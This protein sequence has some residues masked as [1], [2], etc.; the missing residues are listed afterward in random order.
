MNENIEFLEY[1]YKTC[2]MGVKASEK[3]LNVLKEKDNKI[4]KDLEKYLKE[5]EK[6][7]KKSEKILKKYKVEPKTIG[8]MA[9]IMSSFNIKME[10]LQDNSDAKIADMLI[11]GFTCGI[12]D[13]EKRLKNYVK[14]ID[15]DIEKLGKEL[16]DFQKEQ[17][18]TLR[19]YL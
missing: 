8:P 9:D 19:T 10:V 2:D 6:Y 4:K 1:I 5:Y 14:E 7:V 12:V 18:E 15:K 17:T 13:T 16:L 3:L 11:K